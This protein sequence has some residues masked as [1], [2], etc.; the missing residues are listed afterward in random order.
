MGLIPKEIGNLT[1]LEMLHMNRKNFKGHI[2]PDMVH[3]TRLAAL[4]LDHNQISSFSNLPRS[5]RYLS[6]VNNKLTDS[7][8][9]WL[10]NLT[11]LKYLLL[12][13]NQ[14]FDSIYQE[15]G[16][17]SNLT[18]LDLSRNNL[19]GSI[20]VLSFSKL[21]GLLISDNHLS[22]PI[23]DELIRSM[24][25]LETFRSIGQQPEWS[26]TQTSVEYTTT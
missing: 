2:P 1:N 12:D 7:I 21:T 20:P 26:N 17:L 23:P 8:S 24:S 11:N 13:G 18:M 22:G 15:L 14:I 4:A 9:P 5:L 10:G 19:I 3:M 6:L 25:S 16:Y